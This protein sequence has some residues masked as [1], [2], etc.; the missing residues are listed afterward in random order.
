MSNITSFNINDVALYYHALRC[1]AEEPMDT[2][3]AAERSRERLVGYLERR[4]AA[5]SL[6]P[7]RTGMPTL[8][9]KALGELKQMKLIHVEDG[10]VRL[11]ATGAAIVEKLTTGEGRQA[12]RMVLGRM[13]DTFDNLY[14]F[15]KKLS[16]P[17]G[18]EIILP[19][20]RGNNVAAET[21]DD[22]DVDLRGATDLDLVQVCK[23]WSDWCGEHNRP[24]LVPSDFVIRAQTLFDN[25]RDKETGN[26]IKN[27][28]QKLV[29]E[30]ATDGIVEKIPI[31][32]T[33]RDRL[34]TAGAVNSRIRMVDAGS[35]ALEVIYSCLCFGPPE[36]DSE[37]WIRLDVH[38]AAQPI[39]IH[40]PEPEQ[41]AT[42]LY[43][44]LQTA[45]GGLT[46]RAGYY[47]IYEI[48]DRVCE[49]LR[50][51]QGV[52]DAA[53]LYIYKEKQGTISLG[54]DYETI[55]AKRLPI[56]VRDHGRSEHFN[57]VAFRQP[58]QVMLY[59]DHS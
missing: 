34:S 1:V 33:L 27:V 9:T 32:R 16:P 58:T 23:A 37:E 10:K 51:P 21:V 12:R 48:R 36:A 43:A 18:R 14:G 47:R 46:P 52:F 15:V 5:L 25:S 22:S 55:T 45:A 30:Q 26:R 3:V 39:F 28:V 2:A 31:Y 11:L 19:V 17:L 38:R 6:P 40:E 4:R 24:D 44:E 49:A 41:V 54:I 7:L 20:P 59:A 53:F 57:L 42:R 8:G 13:L 35:M 50:I 56:E 29:L